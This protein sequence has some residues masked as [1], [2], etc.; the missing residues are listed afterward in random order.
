MKEV[1]ADFWDN[2]FRVYRD[3]KKSWVHKY[4]KRGFL[5][6]FTGFICSGEMGRNEI[7]NYPVQGTAF[8]CLLKTLI[9]TDKYQE[10]EEWD[11]KII[12]Q[13]HDSLIMDVLPDELDRIKQVLKMIV[14][15]YIP[16]IWGD[17]IIVPLSIEVEEYGVDQPW[18]K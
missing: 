16:S 13:I 12:G 2:R 15:E 14:E 4:R 8:H 11:S 9:E 3:W 1:E 10:A 7:V 17:W 6:M 18:V 5:Q